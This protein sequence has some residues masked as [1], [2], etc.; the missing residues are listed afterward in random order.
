ME[1]EGEKW[2]LTRLWGMAVTEVMESSGALTGIDPCDCGR[3]FGRGVQIFEMACDKDQF[4]LLILDAYPVKCDALHTRP[5]TCFQLSQRVG[6]L[7]CHT[8]YQYLA[9]VPYVP[10]V[11]SL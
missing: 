11:K 7:L 2:G 3:K 10:V 9:L 5:F 1:Q 6:L 4:A 8:V